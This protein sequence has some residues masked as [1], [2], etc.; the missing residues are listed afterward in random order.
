MNQNN[1]GYEGGKTDKICV[2]CGMSN[3]K[4]FTFCK[5]CGARL[6]SPAEN[7]QPFANGNPAQAPPP[8][9][10]AGQG[11]SPYGYTGGNAAGSAPGYTAGYPGFNTYGQVPTDIDGASVDDVSDFVRQS[12]NVYVP[13]FIS[14]YQSGKKVSWNWSVFLLGWLLGPMFAGVWFM[15]RKMYKAGL[16]IIVLGVLLFGLRTAITYQTQYDIYSSSLDYAYE[17]S[18]TTEYSLYGTN[19]ILNSITGNMNSTSFLLNFLLSILSLAATIVL[20]IFA[21]SMYKDFVV[22]SVKEYTAQNGNDDIQQSYAGV[23]MYQ[24][25]YTGNLRSS[26]RRHELSQ[27][28]GRSGAG[29][30]ISLAVIITIYF[31][32]ILAP[33]IE[34]IL[35]HL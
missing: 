5:Q 23:P 31:A 14:M 2:S 4:D 3:E 9:Y 6:N 26:A 12:S 25:G 7:G 33:M 20:S 19:A 13:K 16:L 1:S 28:G 10:N 22:K 21:N 18:D 34:V 24:S 8:G 30:G 32:G 35:N 29:L 15:Y 11:Y 17:N 27:I